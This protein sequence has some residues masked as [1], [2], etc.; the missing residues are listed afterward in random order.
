MA[1]SPGDLREPGRP[2]T[3]TSSYSLL[4]GVRL[5]ADVIT[6]STLVQKCRW[7]GVLQLLRLMAQA[8]HG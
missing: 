4:R 6:F 8:L 7:R 1:R 2:G 3:P 5:V